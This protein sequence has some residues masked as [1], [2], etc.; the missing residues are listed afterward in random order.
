MTRFARGIYRPTAI[1]VGMTSNSRLQWDVLVFGRTAPE[2]GRRTYKEVPLQ[3]PGRGQRVSRKS[4]YTISVAA[5][6]VIAMS[7]CSTRPVSEVQVAGEGRESLKAQWA[8][9]IV[10][11]V[12]KSWTKPAGSPQDFRCVVRLEQSPNGDVKQVTMLGSCGTADLDRSI[13]DAI[14]AANPLPIAPDPAVFEP[15][16]QFTFCSNYST[17]N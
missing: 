17:C 3:S 14:A 16:I 5:A 13:Q 10:N 6:V 15:T 11:K 12:L 8:S 7:A 9:L 1:F 2:L 4:K